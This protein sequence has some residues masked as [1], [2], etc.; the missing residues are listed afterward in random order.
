MNSVKTTMLATPVLE[1]PVHGSAKT[2]G[3]RAVAGTGV[4]AVM[5]VAYSRGYQAGVHI[6][7]TKVFG[8]SA[9]THM[10]IGVEGK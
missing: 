10:F 5:G 3:V 4:V 8:T 1:T 7:P 9:S 2:R 6:Q